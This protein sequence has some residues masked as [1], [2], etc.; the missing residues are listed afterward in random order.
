MNLQK[1]VAA[2]IA[3]SLTLG[4]FPLINS[5]AHAKTVDV[6]V[7]KA[8]V[9][10]AFNAAFSSTKVHLDNYGKKHG[11]SWHQD[12]SYILLPNG[13]ERKFSIPEQKF[14]I[15][16]FRQ[17]KHYINDM[18]TSS[19]QA[20]IKDNRI[21]ATAYF[22]S[23]GEEI[24]GKC[25]KKRF[26]KWK[27]CGL[28]KLERDL[29]LNNT[30]LSISMRPISYYGSISYAKDVNVN[31]KTDIRIA[32]RLCGT[33]KGI[34]GWIEGK[35]KKDLTNNIENQF[36]KAL[37]DDKVRCK[38]A[39]SIKKSLSSRLGKYK[40]WKIVKISSKG[41]KFVLRLSNA[42]VKKECKT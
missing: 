22:E 27:E 7:P 24:K 38:V 13:A 5:P 29:H 36:T 30:I 15:T 18:D 21:Q 28:K 9:A 26:K 35:I 33:F 39:N 16:K 6:P 25:V 8:A 17:W 31:F 11:S 40:R 41:N 37:Q 4:S 10:T 12:S 32:N 42:N 34:C 20:T 2:P 19:I 3:I 1:L 14:S 23:Q